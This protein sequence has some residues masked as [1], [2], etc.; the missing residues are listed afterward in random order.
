MGPTNDPAL[1]PTLWKQVATSHPTL[2]EGMVCY[3]MVEETM[4]EWDECY[5][6]KT[7]KHNQTTNTPT[8]F[9]SPVA[10]LYKSFCSQFEALR[11]RVFPPETT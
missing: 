6:H 8:F 2:L 4:L 11:A 7:I 10:K 5:F 9:T 1:P 3:T